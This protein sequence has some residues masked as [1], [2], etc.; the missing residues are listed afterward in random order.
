VEVG[1]LRGTPWIIGFQS[2]K[3]PL[4]IEKTPLRKKKGKKWKTESAKPSAAWEEFS[5]IRNGSNILKKIDL[6]GI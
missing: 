4:R 5:W 1:G 6:Q 2:E 3:T